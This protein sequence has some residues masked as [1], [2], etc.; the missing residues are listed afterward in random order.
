[1]PFDT[2][3]NEDLM[4]C[5]VEPSRLSATQQDDCAIAD[6]HS[7]VSKVQRDARPSMRPT[8]FKGLTAGVDKTGFPRDIFTVDANDPEDEREQQ[9]RSDQLTLRDDSEPLDYREVQERIKTPSDLAELLEQEAE[10]SFFN[11]VPLATQRSFLIRSETDEAALAEL[12]ELFRRKRSGNRIIAEV[13][14]R[15]AEL[16]DERAAWE[17]GKE[18][19]ELSGEYDW[20]PRA[21]GGVKIDVFR[22]LCRLDQERAV[23]MVYET[24]VRDLESTVGLAT[25]VSNVLEDILGLLEPTAMVRDVW[26]EV[27]DHTSRLLRF[28][29]SDPP[30]DVLSEEVPDDTPHRAIVELITAQLGHPSFAIAQGAQRCLGQ[31]LLDR[32]SDV[33][34][35]LAQALQQSDE[36]RERV[37]MLIDSVSS[38]DPDAVV[39]FRDEVLRLTTSTSWLTRKISRTIMGNCGWPEPAT[40]P[41]L[42]PLPPVYSSSPSRSIKHC[43]QLAPHVLWE[44]RPPLHRS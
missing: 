44:K 7:L 10:R 31:L 13:G 16:G 42:R 43:S 4:T 15:L 33:S 17:M 18:A 19:L 38:I 20:H 35:V 26:V 22:E 32:A 24:L 40:S 8:W 39:Q 9:Y 1:M 29:W 41:I 3:G 5:L 36:Q 2:V 11:W 27:E 34:D 37:L 12:A 25:I 23:P 6:I 21:G 14:K 28:S 30:A